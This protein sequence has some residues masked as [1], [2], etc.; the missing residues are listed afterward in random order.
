MGSGTELLRFALAWLQGSLCFY[1]LTDTERDAESHCNWHA[2]TIPHAIADNIG[3]THAVS[4]ENRNFY[5]ISDAVVDLIA[6]FDP[7]PVVEPGDHAH[8]KCLKRNNTNGITQHNVITV[9]F[10][11]LYGVTDWVSRSDTLT[12]SDVFCEPKPDHSGFINLVSYIIT[13][14]QCVR[15]PSSGTP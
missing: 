7:V 4:F 12:H 8:A 13:D 9:D 14:P 5:P 10:T 11:G 1:G 15:I 6:G 2:I 3:L